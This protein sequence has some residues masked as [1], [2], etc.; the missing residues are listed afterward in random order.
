MMSH[1]HDMSASAGVLDNCNQDGI[2]SQMKNQT[3]SYIPSSS[4]IF[5]GIG[6]RMYSNYSSPPSQAIPNPFHS[7]ASKSFAEH[8]RETQ[9]FTSKCYLNIGALPPSH[10]FPL[11]DRLNTHEHYRNMYSNFQN[12]PYP[13][14]TE[15]NNA[16]ERPMDVQDYSKHSSM[17]HISAASKISS[18]SEVPVAENMSLPKNDDNA[19]PKSMSHVSLSSLK[20]SFPSQ[21]PNLHH[22]PTNIDILKRQKVANNIENISNDLKQNHQEIDNSKLF[23]ASLDT[24][25]VDS[26][27]A[28]VKDSN[29]INTSDHMGGQSF[30][31]V[32]SLNPLTGLLPFKNLTP[33][34]M[35]HSPLEQS[36]DSSYQPRPT[37]NEFGQ[38]LVSQ[39]MV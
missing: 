21:I 2:G 13:Y 37:Y 20:T 24:N 25:A 10:S 26:T 39:D 32:G 11:P 27:P 4:K 31:N 18:P 19:Y 7:L 15:S 38:S 36:A 17:N 35:Q 30:S 1:H 5:A 22:D 6:E 29:Q 12:L 14:R 23:H 9:N 8:M 34:S 16:V 33:S 3:Q 28:N